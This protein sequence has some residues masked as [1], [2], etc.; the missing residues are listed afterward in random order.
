MHPSSDGM[1]IGSFSVQLQKFFINLIL[2][3]QKKKPSGTEVGVISSPQFLQT[4]IFRLFFI[5]ANIYYIKFSILTISKCK[6]SGVNY[7]H[8]FVQ[9][10]SLFPKFCINSNRNCTH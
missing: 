8:Y 6:F 1:S 2:G 7:I 4:L 3:K 10:S 9:S 5:L